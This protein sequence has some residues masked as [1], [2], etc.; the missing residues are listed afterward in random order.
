MKTLNIKG[1]IAQAVFIC[2]AVLGLRLEIPFIQECGGELFLMASL[3]F[4]VFVLK[5][6]VSE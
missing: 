4:I 3:I 2:V 6:G 5:W 1:I